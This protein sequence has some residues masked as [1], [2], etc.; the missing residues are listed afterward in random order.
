MKFEFCCKD[1]QLSWNRQI[2]YKATLNSIGTNVFPFNFCP[3]CGE[4]IEIETKVK[5]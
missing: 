3:F 5:E 2:I 4:K 1:M